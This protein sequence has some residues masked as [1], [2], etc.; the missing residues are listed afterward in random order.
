M[1]EA[2]APRVRVRRL[3]ARARYDR[4]TIT[5]ILDEGIVCHLGFVAGSTPYVLPTLYARI[6]G[7]LYLHGAPA[8]RMLRTAREAPEICLTVTLLD[9]LVLARSAFHHSVN[10]RSV[11]V[12][13]RATEV[14]DQTEKLAAAMA[15]VE[16]VC[17][18]RWG[19]ARQP[20]GGELRATLILRMS[21]DEA[22]AKVRTGHPADDE[23]DLGAPIWAGQLPLQT[24][25][26]EAVPDPCLDGAIA[27]PSYVQRYSRPGW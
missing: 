14:R 23:E 17:R 4:D 6:A 3:P 16:H 10:Y 24:R 26:V 9:G 1:G 19:D 11:V 7:V 15:M 27:M 20:T 21:L 25:V 12:I 8:S 18:G 5:A 2:P 22:S 13:G